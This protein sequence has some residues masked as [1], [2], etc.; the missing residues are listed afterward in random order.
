MIWK[1]AKIPL[2]TAFRMVA[3]LNLILS[4]REYRYVFILGHMRS[5]S[6]LLAHIL[7]SH[8]DFAGA[9]ETHISYQTTADLPKLI[10]KTCELL[11]RPI[12][13]ARYIV[14]QIN[15]SYVANDV[16]LSEHV[17]KCVIL[18]RE[19]GATLKSMMNLLK[20]Q[21]K[22]ALEVYSN[23]LESLTKY[24]LLL[25]ERGVLVEYDDLVDQPEKTLAAL[26]RFFG[27]DSPL[28]PTYATHRM[29]RR[30]AGFGD[31]STNIRAGKIIRT[32]SHEITISKDTLIAA[33]HAFDKCRRQLKT[34]TAQVL[35]RAALTKS[36]TTP[37][38]DQ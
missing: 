37:A 20:C 4:R 21:E 7:A 28:T 33:A 29:T 17:Y 25:G 10:L 23:R 5:G 2:W 26:T 24:G 30:V 35:S 16:L 11:H 18:V 22:E 34:V 14:D 12:L 36:A 19:P 38:S 8:P 3:W 9:G 31:P 27:L 32:P 6:T 13:R 15:H 1:V